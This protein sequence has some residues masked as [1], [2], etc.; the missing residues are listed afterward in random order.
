M[1]GFEPSELPHIVLSDAAV[2][3]DE[4]LESALNGF[5]PI[6]VTFG[7]MAVFEDDG[8]LCLGVSLESADLQALQSEVGAAGYRSR[9]PLAYSD[10]TDIYEFDGVPLTITGQD[11]VVGR[12]IVQDSDTRR[13]YTLLGRPQVWTCKQPLARHRSP[14]R[15]TQG[16]WW[17]SQRFCLVFTVKMHW[18]CWAAVPSFESVG[19]IEA[20]PRCTWAVC[21][22]ERAERCRSNSRGDSGSIAG[23]ADE[24]VCVRSCGQTWGTDTTAV[25]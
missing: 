3:H 8:R 2:L 18:R 11:A 16:V 12:V 5:D 19:R 1:P 10:N 14:Q 13:Q 17:R 23:Q 15:A 4:T 25:E 9:I 24:A 21:T 22:E 7:E 6:E 20:R